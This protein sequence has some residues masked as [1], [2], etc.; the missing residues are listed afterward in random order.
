MFKNQMSFSEFKDF[1][2]HYSYIAFYNY[3]INNVSIIYKVLITDLTPARDL[4]L[5]TYQPRG[6][7]PW[8]PV[9]LFRSYWLMCQYSAGS[10][11]RWVKNLIIFF[12]LYY[13][14]LTMIISQV[15][16]H[17]M[18]LIKLRILTQLIDR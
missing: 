2:K 8:D 4:L 15:S 9:C 3:I 14:D 17:F 7:K 10:I 6:E 12:G 18:I 1:I 16:E 13:Q 11:F 5:H